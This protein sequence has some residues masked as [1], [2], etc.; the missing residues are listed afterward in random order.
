MR[1]VK[2]GQDVMISQELAQIQSLPLELRVAK[3]SVQW[4]MV[5]TIILDQC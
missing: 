1:V 5:T 2:P 4:S 3:D